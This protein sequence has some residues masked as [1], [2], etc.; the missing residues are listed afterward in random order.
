MSDLENRIKKLE[1]QSE[2]DKTRAQIVYV[3]GESETETEAAKQKAIAEYKS[4]HPDWELSH[5]DW[6]I[7]VT[8]EEAKDDL[9]WLIAGGERGEPYLQHKREKRD[10]I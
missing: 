8:D 6:L 10:I 4:K 9:E 7:Q 1:Q 2:G 3:T 5:Q